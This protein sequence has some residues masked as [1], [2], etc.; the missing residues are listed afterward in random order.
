M[1]IYPAF[2]VYPH[3]YPPTKGLPASTTT[4]AAATDFAESEKVPS[5]TS[6][7]AAARPTAGKHGQYH[8][9]TNAK[10]LFIISEIYRQILGF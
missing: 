4:A 9:S 7:Q 8:H 5:T 2:F 6:S 1:L 3:L 10:V